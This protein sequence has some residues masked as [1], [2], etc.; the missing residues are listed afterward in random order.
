[1]QAIAPINRFLVGQVVSEIEDKYFMALL[2]VALACEGI[3]CLFENFCSY[4]L[5][6]G[7]DH[8]D[9]IRI[10][11]TIREAGA[12]GVIDDAELHATHSLQ[13]RHGG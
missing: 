11:P 3:R 13:L 7:A 12:T 2:L 10:V 5:R 9:I 6:N 8:F 4:S 1:M